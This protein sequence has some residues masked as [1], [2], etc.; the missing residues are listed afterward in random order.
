MIPLL[1]LALI[2]AVSA[3]IL[4]VPPS[5]E[6]LYSAAFS[7]DGG[8]FRCLD[9]ST[10]IPMS[11]F[12]DNYRDCADASD[13]PGTSAG[14]RAPF[15]CRNAGYI[16][17]E[18]P[19][20]SVG[21]GICDCCD[22]SDEKARSHSLCTPQCH[23]LEPWRPIFRAVR[24]AYA[25]G[26]KQS[27]LMERDGDRIF[28]KIEAQKKEALAKIEELLL[29]NESWKALPVIKDLDESFDPGDGNGDVNASSSIV[30]LWAFTFRMSHARNHYVQRPMLESEQQEQIQALDEEVSRLRDD[31]SRMEKIVKA[32]EGGFPRALLP[33]WE[34]QFTNNTFSI[35]IGKEIKQKSMRLGK[36]QNWSNGAI[37][38]DQG[39]YC[40]AIR[41]GRSVEIRLACGQENQ[42]GLVEKGQECTYQGTL[43]T[44]MACSSA[45]LAKLNEITLERLAKIARELGIN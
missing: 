40:A 39:E 6:A 36:F 41:K 5:L 45:D 2:P 13:E 12:N 8:S 31:V 20:W 11:R 15:Y 43:L 16:P 25:S 35:V 33:I 44:P 30:R 19:R 34:T 27:I 22:G 24:N 1:G 29:K 26:V 18:I 37:Q 10:V 4:G 17:S 9:N 23:Q 28:Q 42:L 38:Y 14:P 21:D 7:S 32:V 3:H